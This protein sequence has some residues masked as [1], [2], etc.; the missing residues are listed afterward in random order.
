MLMKILVGHFVCRLSANSPF[1]LVRRFMESTKKARK[2]SRKGESGRKEN[3][4][5]GEGK[6]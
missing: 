6:L 3:G 2:K 1:Y 4:D 5:T